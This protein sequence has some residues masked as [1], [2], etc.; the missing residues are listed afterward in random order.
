M[1]ISPHW[2]TTEEP[3]TITDQQAD[4]LAA[5]L[6]HTEGRPN[7]RTA[8]YEH[9]REDL[10]AL[11]HNQWAL[12]TRYMLAAL[13]PLMMPVPCDDTSALAMRRLEG[14]QRQVDT[15]YAELSEDEKD[16]DREWAD[17]VLHLLYLNR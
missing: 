16:K 8:A 6:F 17:R 13:Q 3:P 15:P 7:H 12:W 10:A 2:G 9:L 14:W 11:E 5:D 4:A 1:T